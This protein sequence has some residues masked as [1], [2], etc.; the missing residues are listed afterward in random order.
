MVKMIMNL[1][2]VE[3]DIQQIHDYMDHIA[4]DFQEFD[5]NPAVLSLRNHL[6]MLQVRQQ[7]AINQWPQMGAGPIL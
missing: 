5:N 7:E 1:L 4:A 6:K 2:A 3:Q